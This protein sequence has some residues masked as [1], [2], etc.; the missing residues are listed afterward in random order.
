[1]EAKHTPGPWRL[2]YQGVYGKSGVYCDDPLFAGHT[3]AGVHFPPIYERGETAPQ[4]FAIAEANAHLI[5][6]A[7]DLLEEAQ[8][9]LDL[10]VGLQGAFD[11]GSSEGQF[12][13]RVL[14][15]R[16]MKLRAA[17]SRAHGDVAERSKPNPTPESPDERA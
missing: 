11:D 10:I 6:A 5:A 8:Q 16:A 7:P 13:E 14:A 17:I 3:L 1:M 15:E 12:T 4:A 9:A 2:D